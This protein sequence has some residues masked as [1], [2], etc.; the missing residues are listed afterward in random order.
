MASIN[1]ETV[2]FLPDGREA[3]RVSAVVQDGRSCGAYETSAVIY[4]DEKESETDAV[5]RLFLLM[6]S[7]GQSL[8]PDQE[9]TP[10]HLMFEAPCE[11]CGEPVLTDE[12]SHGEPYWQ[13]SCECGGR[14]LDYRW[15]ISDEPHPAVWS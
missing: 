7:R 11:R 4:L 3:V 1:Y 12:W 6:R 13:T 2:G 10:E 8:H 14:P 5:L 9:N 15:K